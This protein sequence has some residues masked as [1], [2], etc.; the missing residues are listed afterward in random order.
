MFV[1]LT[2]KQLGWRQCLITHSY[3]HMHVHS[4]SCLSLSNFCCRF[5]DQ[6]PPSVYLSAPLYLSFMLSVI[7]GELPEID[8]C[9]CFIREWRE[10]GRGWMWRGKVCRH[11]SEVDPGSIES[12][13][14]PAC[15]KYM[16]KI[17]PR[18][19]KCWTTQ[20]PGRI[21]KLKVL[22]LFCEVHVGLN[23]CC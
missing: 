15:M 4:L 22:P 8:V 18:P 21:W 10:G 5:C 17:W 11:A 1:I 23:F 9:K 14:Q 20:P 16:R 7:V 19:P 13:A 3:Y 12:G 2:S 6:S